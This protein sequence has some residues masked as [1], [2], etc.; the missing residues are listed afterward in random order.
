MQMA[1]RLGMSWMLA[2]AV[3]ACGD[4]SDGGGEKDA[5]KDAAP[6]DMK[7]DSGAPMDT[8]NF[9]C[10]AT[11]CTTP[12]FMIPEGIP[13]PMEIAGA[14]GG[15]TVCELIMACNEGCCTDDGAC[16]ARNTSLTGPDCL[17]QNVPGSP[18]ADCPDVGVVLDSPVAAALTMGPVSVPIPGCCGDDLK[19]GL[20][21]SYLGMG[22]VERSKA[23]LGTLVKLMGD[24]KLPLDSISCT[25][26]A[27]GDDGG[28]ADGG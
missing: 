27:T 23:E 1:S 10:G 19:C 3:V 9:M 28:T 2:L 14:L 25:P 11:M 20:D 22:C 15:G 26:G 21:L 13:I 12:E 4:D 6:P 16:G 8:G 7:K 5:G 24:G 17:E 18:S